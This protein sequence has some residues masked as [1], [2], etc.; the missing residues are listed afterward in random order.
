VK[1]CETYEQVAL[2]LLDKFKDE[3]GLEK[4]QGKQS[5]QGLSSGTTWELDGKGLRK[6]NEAIFVVECKRYT[7]S[8]I[9]QETAASLAYRIKDIS[10]EGGILVS[11]L[12]LQE[13]AKKIANAENII[14]VHLSQKSD[15]LNFLM[16][17]LNQIKAGSNDIVKI[18]ESHR[19]EILGVCEKCN[20]P[21]ELENDENL[22]LKCR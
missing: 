4:I 2:Y 18:S 7:T 16:F 17:F 13:G 19:E 8:K 14:E 3:F 9:K 11:P 10:A 1:N 12:G 15:N 5:V 20:E 6:G 22:C 21:F